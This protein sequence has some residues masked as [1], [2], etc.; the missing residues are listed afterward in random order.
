MCIL[1]RACLIKFR[2]DLHVRIHFYVNT[3]LALVLWYLIRDNFAK[4]TRHLALEQSL[5]EKY[6]QKSQSRSIIDFRLSYS[7]A[8]TPLKATPDGKPKLHP[9]RCPLSRRGA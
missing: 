2:V 5:S 3:H 4:K 8:P 1:L 6:E 7:E 9:P